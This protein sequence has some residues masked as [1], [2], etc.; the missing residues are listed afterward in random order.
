MTDQGGERDIDLVREVYAHFGLAYYQTEVLHRALSSIYAVVPF[1][2]AAGITGPR[3]EERMAQAFGLTLGQLVAAI[4]PWLN[5]ELRT[6]LGDAV[7][8][9]NFLAHQF[10]YDRA[11]LF[12]TDVGLTDVL[13]ELL[14][15]I[16]VFERAERDVEERFQEQRAALGLADPERLAASMADVI[17]GRD[18]QPFVKQ[19]PLRKQETLAH[20]WDVGMSGASTLIFELDDGTLWQLCDVGLGW[21]RFRSRGTDW[22]ANEKVTPYLPSRINP[23]PGAPGAWSYEL[24]LKENTAFVVRLSEKTPK[25]FAWTVRSRRKKPAKPSPAGT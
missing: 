15:H 2:T 7:E 23:R 14:E 9:R 13:S 16:S 1:D 18:T 22:T 17:A 25:A 19:R 6:I 21:T 12:F 11:H 3:V 20:V 8:R 5:D 10:W 4:D 24:S